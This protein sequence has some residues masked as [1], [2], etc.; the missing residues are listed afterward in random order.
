MKKNSERNIGDL[1]FLF[2]IS[3]AN[4]EVGLCYVFNYVESSSGFLVSATDENNS[5]NH[6][7]LKLDPFVSE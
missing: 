7:V 3:I 6:L 2:K 5:D 1:L 4:I